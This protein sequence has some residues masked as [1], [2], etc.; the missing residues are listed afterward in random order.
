[1]QRR[2]FLTRFVASATGASAS[3]AII[4]RSLVA[5][6]PQAASG[7]DSSNLFAMDQSASRPVRLPPK[8]GARVVVSAE[9]RDQI[10][11]RLRCQ[12]GCTLD[13]Y[14][15]RTTD[16]SCQVSPSMHRDVMALVSGGYSAQEILDAFVGTYGERVLMAPPAAGFNLFG[17]LAPFVAL[18]GGAIFVVVVLRKWQRAPQPAVASRARPAR[19]DDATD[20]ERAR[21][22]AAVRDDQ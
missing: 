1:M 20:E 7:L 4:G 5:Q 12:C 3:I 6:A 10:E 19:S 2:Q 8:P 13:V 22:D 11:H 18:G 16:F 14:T 15:C 21:L 9:E 17:W